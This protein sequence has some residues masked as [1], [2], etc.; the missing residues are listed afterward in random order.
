[1]GFVAA[2]IQLSS[3]AAR[4]QVGLVAGAVQVSDG[5]KNLNEFARQFVWV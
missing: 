4:I 1:M 5:K 2:R 3:V